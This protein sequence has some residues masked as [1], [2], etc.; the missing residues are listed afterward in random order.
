MMSHSSKLELVLALLL[1]ASSLSVLVVQGSAKGNIVTH[2]L[3]GQAYMV[4][5]KTDC[6]SCL[7]NSHCYIF[8]QGK[9]SKIAYPCL[10]R[11]CWGHAGR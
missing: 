9:D 8:G 6:Q 7:I 10:C 2:P 11:P 5:E 1:T 3:G 4:E